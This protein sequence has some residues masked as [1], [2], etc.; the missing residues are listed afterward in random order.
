V[1][2][3]LLSKA[4][5]YA[6]QYRPSDGEW[7]RRL[8]VGGLVNTLLGP[9]ETGH[10]FPCSAAAGFGCCGWWGVGGRF[11]WL[12]RALGLLPRLRGWAG[13]LLVF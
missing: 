3:W 13:V 2:H 10:P 8:W 12:L 6:G 7:E 1:E 4:F 5:T 11:S 9:E